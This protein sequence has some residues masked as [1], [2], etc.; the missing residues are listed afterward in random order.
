MSGGIRICGL[1]N[2]LSNIKRIQE[3][4]RNGLHYLTEHAYDEAGEDD[5][6]IYDIEQGI[7]THKM[8]KNWPREGTYELVGFGFG[9]AT[10]RYGVTPHRVRKSSRHHRLRGQTRDVER[11]N[12]HELP[13][14]SKS[15]SM[16]RRKEG[17]GLKCLPFPAAPPKVKPWKNSRKI[18]MKPLKGVFPATRCIPLDREQ[19]AALTFIPS[20]NRIRTVGAVK[21]EKQHRMTS[22]D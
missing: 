19:S 21:C 4:V 20:R 22:K 7:M 14:K 9:R 6:D 15:S 8:R 16:K 13:G 17:F 5:F 10:H 18:Y 12:R 11:L 1:W 3:L 2:I